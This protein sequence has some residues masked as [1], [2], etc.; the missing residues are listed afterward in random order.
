ME[1]VTEAAARM[2]PH[3]KRLILVFTHVGA[4]AAG[5]AIAINRLQVKY[6]EL[7]DQEIA[8]A[9]RHYEERTFPSRQQYDTP[10]E[11]LK[12]LLNGRQ[13]ELL[14]EGVMALESYMGEEEKPG[15]RVLE[16]SVTLVETNIFDETG[17]KD[18][19]ME[20]ELRER[21]PEFPYILSKDE[22]LA[23]EPGWPQ[24]SLTYYAGDDV[25][26]D[27]SDQIV[28]IEATIGRGILKRFGHGSGEENIVYVRNVK[29]EVD[30]DVNRSFGTYAHEV[31][32]FDDDEDDDT[33]T[34]SFQRMPRRRQHLEE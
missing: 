5:A 11:A 6:A 18:L 10:E 31:A 12:A 30:Y 25:L 33:L 7:A 22:F 3:I 27:I 2:S 14:D 21:D 19:D 26:T 9:R 8:E 23:A 28:D 29:L 13:Q 4:A 24:L 15:D 16:T 1:E 32:G 20:K 34:H 17:P